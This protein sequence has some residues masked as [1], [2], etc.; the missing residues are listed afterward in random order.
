[1]QTLRTAGYVGLMVVALTAWTRKDARKE[2]VR[3]QLSTRSGAP[4]LVHV[5]TRGL[6]AL[7]PRLSQ[8]R[9]P[10]QVIATI[11]APS[12]LSFGGVGEADIRLVDSA[13]TLIVDVTQVRQSAPP[14]Q[15]LVG[16]AFRVSRAAYT[17]P[18]RVTALEDDATSYRR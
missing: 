2:Y 13:A 8:A 3:L 4:A 15:R 12:E 16:Q 10:W 9:Q 5:T 18:F 14:A 6:I 17:D 1:M 11:S 7:T